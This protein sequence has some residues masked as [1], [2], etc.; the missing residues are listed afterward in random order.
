MDGWLGSLAD[1]GPVGPKPGPAGSR[2]K[3]Y[4]ASDHIAMRS[5]LRRVSP[6]TA[7]T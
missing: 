5:S 3:G 7:E 6:L 1:P 2:P 4:N